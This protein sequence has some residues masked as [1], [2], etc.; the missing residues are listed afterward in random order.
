MPVHKPRPH[1]YALLVDDRDD[2]L[3]EKDSPYVTWFARAILPNGLKLLQ[4]ISV[5]FVSL[6]VIVQSD[7]LIELLKD[8]T[9]LHFVSEIDN[10]MFRVALQGYFGHDLK[11]RAEK[12]MHVKLDDHN[13]ISMNNPT[14]FYLIRRNLKVLILLTLGTFMFWGWT[15]FV[16]GQISGRF[17]RLKYRDCNITDADLFKIG[18]GE[19]CHGFYNTFECGFDGG[20]CDDFNAK[21]PNCPVLNTSLVGDGFC[22]GGAYDTIGCSKDGGDCEACP[23][24]PE[25]EKDTWAVVTADFDGDSFE[26]IVFGNCGLSNQLILNNG[27]ETWGKVIDLP[28]DTSTC[29]SSIAAADLDGDGLVDMVIGNMPVGGFSGNK[30]SVFNHILWNNG[31]DTFDIME[32]PGTDELDTLAIVVADLNND[33]FPEIIIGTHRDDNV[34]FWNNQNRTFHK[35]II[36]SQGTK[37]ET[38]DIAVITIEDTFHLIFGNYDQ[39]NTITRVKAAKNRTSATFDAPKTLLGGQRKTT[40]IAVLT[41]QNDMSR[42]MAFHILIGNDGQRNQLIGVYNLAELDGGFASDFGD[43]SRTQSIEIA[44]MNNDGKSEFVIANYGE[45]NQVLSYSGEDYYMWSDEITGDFSRTM[46]VTHELPC[47]TYTKT[48]VIS[49]SDLDNDGVLDIIIGNGH[50]GFL[51]QK[52]K[53]K[54]QVL[55]NFL[56][57]GITY[58]QP[59]TDAT[60]KWLPENA[61]TPAK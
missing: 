32:L 54:N 24:V 60:K 30:E 52:K 23:R 41:D 6:I 39:D 16:R 26:D 42:D 44:D 28:G 35:I 29:T 1:L 10:I 19:T 56:G 8:F 31:D 15:F 40:S 12:V 48:A 61:I 18:D 55:F 45:S 21:Y 22:N 57:D 36:D 25:S 7:D 50:G 46:K 34:I 17:V 38:R 47:S 14:F 43:V 5:I 37:P 11:M 9:A 58:K 33:S 51:S 53:H 13:P 2:D 49:T 3:K 27:D 59:G 20:D 4:G